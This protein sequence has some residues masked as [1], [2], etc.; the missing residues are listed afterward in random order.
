MPNR[1][2]L[3]LAASERLSFFDEVLEGVEC[4]RVT[5]V[6]DA[7]KQCVSD[8]PAAVLMDLA[9]TLHAGVSETAPLY[10]LGIDLPILRCTGG[11]GA[12]WVGMCQAPFKRMPL[13]QAI[14]EIGVGEPSWKHPVNLRKF[15][16]VNQNARVWFRKA[17]AEEWRRANCQSMSVSGLFLLTLEPE[18][19]GADIELRVLDTTAEEACIKGAV[20]WVH[21]WEDGSHIPGCGV[22]FDRE[23]V[24]VAFRDYLANTFFSRRRS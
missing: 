19:I 6:L 24:P 5:T 1:P 4:V 3:L 12:P 15:V 9:S 16:R 17:G 2:F 22:N 10:D 23:T 7:V 21:K 14:A 8:P 13:D 11:N 18:P 20:V